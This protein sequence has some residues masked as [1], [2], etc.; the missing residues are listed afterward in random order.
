M[1]EINELK[2]KKLDIDVQKKNFKKANTA[3]IN[4]KGVEFE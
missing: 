2:I 1:N 4:P 3:I